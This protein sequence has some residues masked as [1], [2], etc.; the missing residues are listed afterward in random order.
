MRNSI[1][2]NSPDVGRMNDDLRS[3]GCFSATSSRRVE[4]PQLGGGVVAENENTAVMVMRTIST[5]QITFL[6]ATGNYADDLSELVNRGLLDTQYVSDGTTGYVYQVHPED[7]SLLFQGK[8]ISTYSAVATPDD[9]GGTYFYLGPFAQGRCCWPDGV[10]RYA[11]GRP[12]AGDS[13]PAST[14]P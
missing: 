10:V 12:A 1:D 14:R 3:V 13:P 5:A 2:P 7:D 8:N 4:S 11:I 6:N 9:P